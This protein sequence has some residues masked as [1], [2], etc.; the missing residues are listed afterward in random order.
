MTCFGMFLQ[1]VVCSRRRTQRC[2]AL[3]SLCQDW[4]VFTEYAQRQRRLSF[5]KLQTVTESFPGPFMWFESLLMRN[6]SRF[7]NF[8]HSQWKKM[9]DVWRAIVTR[10][11]G[12]LNHSLLWS[13]TVNISWTVLQLSAFKTI[14]KTYVHRKNNT[15]FLILN[16]DDK[17]CTLTL[18]YSWII[19]SDKPP[20]QSCRSIFEHANSAFSWPQSSLLSSLHGCMRPAAPKRFLLSTHA[21]VVGGVTD[22]LRRSGEINHEVHLRV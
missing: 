18:N 3:C 21:A 14:D 1:D 19:P 12:S 20:S 15:G 7:L 16:P 2:S 11:T 4:F 22:A 10:P 5:F 6:F 17:W 8:S 9:T 13:K